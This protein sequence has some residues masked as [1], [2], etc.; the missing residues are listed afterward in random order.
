MAVRHSEVTHKLPFCVA[1][2]ENRIAL[3]HFLRLVILIPPA[4]VESN[5]LS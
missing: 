3:G 4:A 5:I 2:F 1:A